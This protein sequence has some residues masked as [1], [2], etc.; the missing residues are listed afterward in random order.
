MGKLSELAKDKKKSLS[1][2]IEN[3]AIPIRGDRWETHN[4]ISS[5]CPNYGLC[6]TCKESEMFKKQYSGW[7][8]KC[9]MW[10]RMLSPVDPIMECNLYRERGKLSLDAMISM[11]YLIEPNKNKVGLV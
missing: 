6:N 1:D 5:D 9:G 3:M 4:S 2:E 10:D 7:V 11:A 8:G